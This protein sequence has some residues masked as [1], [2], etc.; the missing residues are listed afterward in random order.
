LL[1]VHDLLANVKIDE[2]FHI[3]EDL[4]FLERGVQQ[5]ALDETLLYGGW[6]ERWFGVEA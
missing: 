2:F 4:G 1:E 6:G 3:V 5:M